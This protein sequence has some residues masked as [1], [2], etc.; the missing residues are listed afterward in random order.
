MLTGS[1]AISHIP[2]LRIQSVSVGVFLTVIAGKLWDEI[3]NFRLNVKSSNRVNRGGSWN[4]T[5]TNTR[6]AYR[7]N[8]SESNTNNNLGLRLALRAYNRRSWIRSEEVV[9]RHLSGITGMQN[10]PAGYI[11]ADIGSRSVRMSSRWFRPPPGPE[12]LLAYVSGVWNDRRT[13]GA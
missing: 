11:Q 1:T 5:A 6:V 7:N 3:K 10:Q 9:N 12:S 13:S 2:S 8:N 4:N